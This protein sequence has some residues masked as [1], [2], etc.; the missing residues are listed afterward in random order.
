MGPHAPFIIASYGCVVL[1]VG[2]LI[3]WLIEDGRATAARIAALEAKGV[4]RRSADATAATES[5][6][7]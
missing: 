6:T 7:S 4:R 2:A 1:A 5:P 3:V